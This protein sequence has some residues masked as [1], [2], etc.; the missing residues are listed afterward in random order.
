MNNLK[1]TILFL[2]FC[3]G[4]RSFLVYLAYQLRNKHTLK[5]LGTI[6]LI[7]AIGFIYLYFSN[8][9][10]NANEAGGKTWWHNLRIIHG[11]LYL[12]FSICAL[13]G[14]KESWI[15]LL[16]DVIIGFFASFKIFSVASLLIKT[17]L[18]G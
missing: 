17:F 11:I 12:N 1:R 13:F 18:Y 15:F 9:R 4:L 16:I 3:L 10:L 6:T 14:V 7:P 5:I 8:K 2:V